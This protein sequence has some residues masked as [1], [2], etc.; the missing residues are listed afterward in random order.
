MGQ[1][2]NQ[3]NAM[4]GG[5]DAVLA[6]SSFRSGI[7]ARAKDCWAQGNPPDAKAFLDRHPELAS[8]KSIVL[9]L[10]YEE[11]CQR[12]EGGESID[13]AVYCRRFPEHEKSLGRLIAVH[14]Y[15]EDNVSL[16]SCVDVDWPEPGEEFLGFFVV[17]ELPKIALLFSP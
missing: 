8:R 15:L 5:P 9:D 10:A 16:L 12:V 14:D 7:V 3:P 2:S 6:E 1:R 13:A 11:Y 4:P 17:A